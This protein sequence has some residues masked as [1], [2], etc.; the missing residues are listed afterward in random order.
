MKNSLWCI[1]LDDTLFTS[2]MTYVREIDANGIVTKIDSVAWSTYVIKPECRYDFSAFRC[3]KIFIDTSVRIS[4]NWETIW[5]LGARDAE[6]AIVTARQTFNNQLYL[7]YHLKHRLNDP[8]IT[9]HCVGDEPYDT[10]SECK[11]HV[12]D[13][14]ITYGGIDYKEVVLVD[15]SISNL[16]MF[17]KLK[18]K[19]TEKT[20]KTY[21][22]T[23]NGIALHE[24]R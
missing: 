16:N 18:E 1:D 8:N 19:Y 13:R 2:D 12:I 3:E 22:V 24:I 9:V 15:D 20:F 4:N 17:L 11:Y 6:R 5:E 21:H 7:V 10:A 14:L 23:D